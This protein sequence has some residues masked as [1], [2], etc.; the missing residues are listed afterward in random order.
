MK[1][2]RPIVLGLLSIPGLAQAQIVLDNTQTPEQLV[3][4]VLLGGG[5]QVSNITFNGAPAN[6]LTE[7]MGAFNGT[8]CNVGITSGIILA[9]GNMNVAVGPNDEPAY[10]NGGGDYDADDADLEILSGIDVNDAAVL[11]FDFIPTGD[12]LKFDF[13]FGSEEYPEYVCGV[14]DAFGFFLSGPGING[15]FTNNAINIALI[16]G[17]TVPISINT[18]NNGSVGANGMVSS[19]VAS[20]PNWN[21]HTAFYVANGDGST[22]PYANDP[23]YIQYDGFTVV[24]TARAQV[25]CGL[26]YHI[27]IAVADA[28]DTAFDSAVFLQAGSFASTGSVVPQLAEGVNMNDSTMFEG[29]GTVPLQFARLG[30]TTNVDTVQIVIG[31]TATA[32][33]DYYP[34]LPTQ[35]IF[36]PGDSMITYDLT[37]PLDGDG[38]ETITLHITQNIVCSGQVVENDYTFYIDQAPPLQVVTDD[39]NGACGQTYVLAPAVSGGAGLYQYQW[40]TGGTGPSIT[41][42]PDT[43]TTYYVLVS[44]TC[45]VSPVLDSVVV[46][47]PVY[48]PLTIAVSDDVAIPC[49][50]TEE[51]GVTQTLG[52]NGTYVY[53]WTAN[54]SVV[55]GTAMIT[56]PAGPPT[57]YI[58]LVEEG[59]GHTATDTVRVSTIPL[60]SIVITAPD[61]TV[62]CPGD[63]TVLRAEEVT[64][65]NGVYSYVWQDAAGAVL[66]TGDTLQVPVTADVSYLLTVSDQCSYVSDTLVWTYLPVYAPFELTV[67]ADTTI[68]IGASIDLWAQVRGGSEQY[69]LDWRGQG[70]NDPHL[71][72]TPEADAVYNVDVLDRC[73]WVLGDSVEVIVEHPQARILLANQGE[74]DWLFQAATYPY[75]VPVL[76]WDLGDG[77]R[78]RSTAVT[79]SY[80]DLADHWV[81][82]HIVSDAGCEASDSVLVK[83]PGN[84]FL[85]T[86]FTPDGDGIN[87]TFGPVGHGIEEFRMSIFD[88]WGHLVFETEELE[89]RWD[90]KVNGAEEA[91]TGVYV[92]KYRAKGHYFEANEVYGHVTLLRGA[93][94]K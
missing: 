4:N 46:T 8:N 50:G 43:T 68:C 60:P 57:D 65:G 63:T 89:K 31:G 86:A 18:V 72:L 13:V 71:V 19:C 6:V 17:T 76:I 45:S 28:S 16:P 7:Q 2:F 32:G 22:P 30:D 70:S 80:L 62:V 33:V 9:T 12:S 27:K 54:G 55:G 85:P 74:D 88:R 39:I 75:L 37:V 34:Q 61:I 56:V 14:N 48:P 67:T 40:S 49:L 66:S 73:G 94:S 42:S 78:A 23:Y 77:T 35:L 91:T 82:L 1:A 5:V 25:T 29:C 84:I 41:V 20:D 44:D 79:H 11:E 52:G 59:C 83:P 26:T 3:Q 90:G 10:S 21:T 36:Q 58:V 81:T 93:Q 64:G 47:I 92:Y 51:I 87:E 15:P 53:T 38:P 69:T 24:L